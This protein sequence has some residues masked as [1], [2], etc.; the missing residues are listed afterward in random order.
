MRVQ[1]AP[2]KYARNGASIVIKARCQGVQLVVCNRAQ[3][4]GVL[5]WNDDQVH[6]HFMQLER[7][8]S[9]L[10]RSKRLLRDIVGNSASNTF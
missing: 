1:F 3:F 5:E 4:R 8:I 2:E 10:Q 9:K 6:V 7:L